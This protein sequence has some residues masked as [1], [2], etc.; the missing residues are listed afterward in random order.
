MI[1]YKIKV[2]KDVKLKIDDKQLILKCFLVVLVT[3]C[4]I[5]ALFFILRTICLF[6]TLLRI[7]CYHLLTQHVKYQ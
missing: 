1:K 4:S 2:V 6:V 3:Y 7:A 5:S